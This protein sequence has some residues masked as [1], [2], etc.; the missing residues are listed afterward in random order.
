MPIQGDLAA[1][2]RQVVGDDVVEVLGPQLVRIDWERSE[3]DLF[4]LQCAMFSSLSSG[5]WWLDVEDVPDLESLSVMGRGHVGTLVVVPHTSLSPRLFRDLGTQVWIA[6]TGS[7]GA[8]TV[9]RWSAS[10][11]FAHP[12]SF[13][14]LVSSSA[15]SRG[16]ASYFDSASWLVT[17]RSE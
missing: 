7:S 17:D 5:E 14:S 11:L 13:P 10:D 9:G 15:C 2:V 3:G 4:R 8:V 12:E 1:S 6:L 16:I